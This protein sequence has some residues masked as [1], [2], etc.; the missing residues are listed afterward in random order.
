MF[1][2]YKVCETYRTRIIIVETFE[3]KVPALFLAKSA[4]LSAFASGRSTA[5]IIDGG[6]SR[7]S[8]ST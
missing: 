8:T 7:S 4:V 6:N 3:L 5:L 2:K 1:E